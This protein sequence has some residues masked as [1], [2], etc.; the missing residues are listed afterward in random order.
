MQLRDTNDLQASSG[1]YTI[2]DLYEIFS[3]SEDRNNL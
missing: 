2:V 1:T 3:F